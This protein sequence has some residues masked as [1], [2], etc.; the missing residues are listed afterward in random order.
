LRRWIGHKKS[1]W[2]QLRPYESRQETFGIG[3]DGSAQNAWI[4]PPG[5]KTTA[6]NGNPSLGGL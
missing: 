1:P 2:N 5:L 4:A 6:K 3:R